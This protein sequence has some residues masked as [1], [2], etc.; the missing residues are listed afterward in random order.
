[1]LLLRIRQRYLHEKGHHRRIT[2][3]QFQHSAEGYRDLC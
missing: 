2:T 3:Q 1:L